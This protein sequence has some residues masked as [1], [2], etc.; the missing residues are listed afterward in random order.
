MPKKEHLLKTWN[1]Y[2]KEVV[3]GNKTFDVRKNDRNFEV[4]DLLCLQEYIPVGGYYTGHEYWVKITYVLEG[5]NFGI[6]K[7]FVVLGIKKL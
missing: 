1:P 6:E 4:G 2:Y 7:G 5:G 3:R